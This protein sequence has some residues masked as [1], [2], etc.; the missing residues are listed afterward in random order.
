MEYWDIY[1]AQ[2]EKTG[3]LHRRGDTL[4][5]GEYHLVANVC[6]L[7]GRGEMLLQK[8]APGRPHPN[9]WEC[10]GGSVLAGEDSFQGA[11]REA[12]EEFGADLSGAP[13]RRVISLFREDRHDFWDMWLFIKDI[14]L[15]NL[16]L[17]E[18]EVS[19]AKWVTKES[20]LA[21]LESGEMV[22]SMKELVDIDF[23]LKEQDKEC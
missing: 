21:L 17:Q 14:P 11:L 23:N 6:I 4:N 18:E 19:D 12:R 16:S 22:D 7:N 9:L 13:C 20:F 10:G 15:S 8:R 5:P 3:E 2:R 1:N